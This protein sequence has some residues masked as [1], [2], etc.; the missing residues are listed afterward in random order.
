MNKLS[1]MKRIYILIL[2]AGLSSGSLRAQFA[3]GVTGQSLIPTA[4]MQQT[5]TFMG[6]AN[7][8]PEQ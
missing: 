2:L 5:G 4:E 8:L 1:I 3:L 6:G 7:F